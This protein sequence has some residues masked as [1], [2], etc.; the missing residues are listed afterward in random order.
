MD[1]ASNLRMMMNHI[2]KKKIPLAFLSTSD[3]KG[4]ENF[5]EKFS[6]YYA[7]KTKERITILQSKEENERKL[8]EYVTVSSVSLEVCTQKQTDKKRI[9]RLSREVETIE[10]KEERIFYFAGKGIETKSINLSSLA[11]NILFVMKPTKQSVVELINFVKVF[12][13]IEFHPHIMIVMD[14]GDLKSYEEENKKMEE[15]CMNHF[16]SHIKYIGNCE[17]DYLSL[18]DEEELFKEIDITYLSEQN[19]TKSLVEALESFEF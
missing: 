16:Q 3:I 4:E 10:Q 19:G 12:H 5:V 2:H 18:F 1:Q 6:S 15:F 7:N 17:L 9:E 13:K 8:S 11:E 14:T